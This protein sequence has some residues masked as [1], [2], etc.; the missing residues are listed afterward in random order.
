MDLSSFEMDFFIQQLIDSATSLGFAPSD[1]KA[2]YLSLQQFNSR[3]SPA[4]AVPGLPQKS[5]VLNSVCLNKDCKLDATP[6]CAL[7]PVSVKP[8]N[9]T[10]AALNE[11]TTSGSGKG[12][13]SATTNAGIPVQSANEGAKGRVGEAFWTVA[14]VALAVAYV[15]MD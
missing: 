6:N 8:I 2:F 14:V 10:E 7:Y 1:T 9:A 4:S 12:N 5:A 13:G 15:K 3:C 11:T